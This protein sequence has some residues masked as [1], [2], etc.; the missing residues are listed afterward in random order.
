MSLLCF[1]ELRE[2]EFSALYP[3]ETYQATISSIAS[4]NLSKIVFSSRS[5]TTT[6]DIFQSLFHW[7]DFDN[8]ISALAD[9]LRKLGN[10]QTLEMEFR[11]E[12]V[13]LDQPRDLKGFL[14]KFREKGRVR[15]ADLSHGQV[16]EL[17]VCF[18]FCSCYIVALS[19]LDSSEML[20]QTGHVT[21]T[22]QYAG[23]PTGVLCRR[24]T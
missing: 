9:K 16:L 22:R 14:P 21:G 20:G 17:A 5:W 8:C 6:L 12:L 7:V 11:F 15:I 4:I 24:R 23:F 19:D 2:V 3:I 13:P 10:K 1:S 18:P